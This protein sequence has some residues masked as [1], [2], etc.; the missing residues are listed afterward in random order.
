MPASKYKKGAKAKGKGDK[1]KKGAK[2][3]KRTK[4]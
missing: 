2:K 1:M 3:M 4:K